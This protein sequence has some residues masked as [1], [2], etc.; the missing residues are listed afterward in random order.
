MDESAEDVLSTHRSRPISRRAWLRR[1]EFEASVR[2]S[3]VVMTDVLDENR[4]EVLA[5][6]DEEVVQAVLSHRSH[7]SFGEC[8][9]AR[10]ADGGLDCLDADRSEHGV[11]RRGELGVS[12]AHEETEAT[13]V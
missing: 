9:R 12:V 13:T 8:I 1:D 4:L 3:P 10:R 2:S 5:A 6:E 11:E 7:P